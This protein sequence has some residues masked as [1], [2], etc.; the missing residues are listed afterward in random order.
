MHLTLKK[1]ATHP[2]GFNSLQQQARCDGNAYIGNRLR[3][4]LPRDAHSTEAKNQAADFPLTRSS[5][6]G[7][8][9]SEPA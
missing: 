7:W 4:T 6:T 9:Q 2:P 3:N 5:L 1:E 8:L